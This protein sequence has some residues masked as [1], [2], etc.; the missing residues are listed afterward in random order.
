M[1]GKEKEGGRRRERDKGEGEGK[2]RENEGELR[3]G[4]GKGFARPKS[5]CF[6]R[7]GS[8]QSS[9]WQE[10]SIYDCCTAHS[11]SAARRRAS[12]TATLSAYAAL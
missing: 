12:A 4:E 10:I 2:V 9:C 1:E 11:S 3:E 8:M 5:N 6:L 7:A